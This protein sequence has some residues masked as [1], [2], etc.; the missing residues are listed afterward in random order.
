MDEAIDFDRE[1]MISAIIEAGE[2]GGRKINKAEAEEIIE[3]VFSLFGKGVVLFVKEH[4]GQFR[5]SLSYDKRFGH[6]LLEVVI[7]LGHTL[8]ALKDKLYSEA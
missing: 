1:Q 4:D 6:S 5:L 3:R 7:C 8:Q 2:R